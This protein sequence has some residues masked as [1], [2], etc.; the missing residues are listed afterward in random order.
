[1]AGQADDSW[2]LIDN[3]D[4]MFII[5][6]FKRRIY[7]SSYSSSGVT[8]HIPSGV[9]KIRRRADQQTSVPDRIDGH[10]AALRTGM[11]ALLLDLGI[12]AED[13]MAA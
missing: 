1:L 2:T 5:T 12:T 13:H 3:A 9:S 10:Y 6:S 11:Q 8:T 4:I 7:R